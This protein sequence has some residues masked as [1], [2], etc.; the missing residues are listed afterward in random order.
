MKRSHRL[1]L[2]GTAALLCHCVFFLCRGYPLRIVSDSFG[3]VLLNTVFFIVYALLLIAALRE[4]ETLF[5]ATLFSKEKT[6]DT[7]KLFACLLG[8]QIAF[9]V[10]VRLAEALPLV[11][12][13]LLTSFLSVARLVVFCLFLLRKRRDLLIGRKRLTGMAVLATSV[14]ACGFLFDFLCFAEY[15]NASEVFRATSPMLTCA[16]R[17][18]E[19]FY[20]LKL[21]ISDVILLCGL[22]IVSSLPTGH[23]EETS[24]G[25][26][27]FVRVDVTVAVA[28]VFWVFFLAV[29]PQSVFAGVS[30]HVK[31]VHY[32]MNDG[33]YAET[34]TSES[35][36]GFGTTERNV[37]YE[38]ER[39]SLGREED[40]LLTIPRPFGARVVLSENETSPAGF[41]TYTLNGERLYLYQ[42]MAV[43]F[44]EDSEPIAVLLTE[45][46]EYG[47]RALLTDFCKTALSE[48][49]L[50]V[51]EY[52]ADYLLTYESEFVRPYIERYRAGSFSE[53]ERA[54]LDAA[55]YREDYII[56]I[57]DQI[58]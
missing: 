12:S 16:L 25:A 47:E 45:L 31:L 50:F 1:F 52:A 53:N 27:L 58:P 3:G 43:C 20:D 13:V 54:W 37:Q 8:M 48:G 22:L 57:A 35:Y 55:Q 21:L 5:T 44:F 40:V 34:I 46:A 30:D 32:Q 38:R 11:A 23:S 14:L 39:I 9:D 18:A 24:G 2:N 26:R 10:L 33:F 19:F 15:R 28:I 42:G 29:S 36:R 6:R 17:D 4:E 7:M 49:N 56:M 51:F 41:T